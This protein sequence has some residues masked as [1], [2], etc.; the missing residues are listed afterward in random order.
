MKS[1]V[2]VPVSGFAEGTEMLYLS[3]KNHISWGFTGTSLLFT[4]YY[5]EPGADGTIIGDFGFE[6]V[7]LLLSMRDLSVSLLYR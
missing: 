6:I 7:A 2:N 3:Q 1:H 4:A 5:N